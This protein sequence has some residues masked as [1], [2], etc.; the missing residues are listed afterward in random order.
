MPHP[1]RPL[2][3]QQWMKSQTQCVTG[4]I[5]TNP[6]APT[7]PRPAH[8]A[9]HRVGVA[10]ATARERGGAP[11]ATYRST[12]YK[13]GSHQTRVSRKVPSLPAPP[14]PH[15]LPT[16]NLTQIVASC[17]SH[18]NQQRFPSRNPLDRAMDIRCIARGV[19]GM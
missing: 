14:P 8:L 4:H 18:N 9:P 12:D 17:L 1:P 19:R 3:L 15:L 6:T 11:K 16:L 2:I 13:I 7:Q 5:H 10:A